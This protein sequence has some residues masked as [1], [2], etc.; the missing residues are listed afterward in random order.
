[1]NNF[2][3]EGDRGPYIELIQSTLKKLGFYFEKIDGVFGTKTKDAV[4]KFQR[5]FGLDP[6]GIVGT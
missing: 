3:S 2:F 4:I 6:D 1:M 5:K